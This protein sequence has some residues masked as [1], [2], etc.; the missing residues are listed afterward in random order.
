MSR[1]SPVTKGHDSRASRS[2]HHTGANSAAARHQHRAR[3]TI[4]AGWLVGL[5]LCT[6]SQTVTT[7]CAPNA[8]SIPAYRNKLTDPQIA[9]VANYV[10]NAWGNA[11]PAV[12]GDRGRRRAR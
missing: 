10:R 7:A 2:I 9:A 1:R 6:A 11:A 4:L 5:L 12:T 8:G 3:R